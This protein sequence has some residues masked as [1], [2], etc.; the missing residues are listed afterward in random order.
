MG[1]LTAATATAVL[2]PG[3]V[4][5]VTCFTP[6]GAVDMAPSMFV[7]HIRTVP[8]ASTTAELRASM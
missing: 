1:S 6:F 2:M 3:M 7:P 5:G 8:S 4:N